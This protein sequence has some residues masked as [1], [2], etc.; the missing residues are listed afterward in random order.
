ME[1]IVPSAF[2]LTL[3]K[4]LSAHTTLLSREVEPI[5]LMQV[6]SFT[7]YTSCKLHFVSFVTGFQKYTS[8]SSFCTCCHSSAPC[9][10]VFSLLWHAPKTTRT[11]ST[12]TVAVPNKT[13]FSPLP[14]VRTSAKDPALLPLSFCTIVD[15]D[16]GEGVGFDE[17]GRGGGGGG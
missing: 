16:E 2:P 17:G 7:L 3:S 1:K 4:S 13:R 5:V 15:D 9:M 10:P 8:P 14:S 12:A 11:A 6:L